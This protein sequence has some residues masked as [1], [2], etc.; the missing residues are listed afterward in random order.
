MGRHGDRVA[1][2]Q[3]GGRDSDRDHHAGGD[4]VPVGGAGRQRRLDPVIPGTLMAALPV[5]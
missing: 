4:E 5:G 1:T 3:C 2:M